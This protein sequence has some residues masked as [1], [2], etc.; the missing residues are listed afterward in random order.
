MVSQVQK[1]Y[2]LDPKFRI[3]YVL[4]CSFSQRGR[5]C[6]IMRSYIH[7]TLCKVFCRR[8]YISRLRAALTLGHR[9]GFE[10]RKVLDKKLA[11]ILK[12]SVSGSC[13]CNI[14]IIIITC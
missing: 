14:I 8:H 2:N 7:V 13:S 9:N 4:Y 10:S 6:F 11:L 5:I 1:R 3:G 12:D